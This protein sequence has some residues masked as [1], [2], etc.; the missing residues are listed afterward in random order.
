MT[1]TV[2][3][4]GADSMLGKELSRQLTTADLQVIKIGRADHN[5]VVLDLHSP[6]LSMLPKGCRADVLIH[7]A[8]SFDGS[9]LAKAASTY[10]VNAKGCLSVL[11]M[12]KALECTQCVYA[13]TISS[14][15][16]FDP[17]GKSF[18]G[19]S[20]AH[21][22]DLLSWGL[23]KEGGRFCSIRLTH[24]YDSY[25]V[26][27]KH[28]PWFGRI[29]AYTSRGLALALP[30][31][32]GI[33]NYLHV[34]DAARFII[35]AAREK[36]NGCWPLCHPEQMTHEAIAHLANREFDMGSH[37]EIDDAKNRFRACNYPDSARLFN[38]LNMVPSITMEAGLHQI[39]ECG[40]AHLYGPLDVI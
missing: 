34:V 8:A 7:C 11:A 27:C 10:E 26:C 33:R 14:Y 22:E 9:S 30:G 29:I 40:A 16:R 13:G 4:L 32:D 19:I 39:S 20:K 18:Y 3:L 15:A 35:G 1:T 25:G 36:L 21:G 12:M 23:E 24:L 38:E 5:D 6:D 37:I 31:S 28:Q 17:A 2:A